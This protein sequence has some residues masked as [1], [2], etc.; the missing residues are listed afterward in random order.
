MEDPTLLPHIMKYLKYNPTF[1]TSKECSQLLSLVQLD[2]LSDNEIKSTLHIIL[3]CHPRSTFAPNLT[4]ICIRIINN[5]GSWNETT[6]PIQHLLVSRIA[7]CDIKVNCEALLNK[8]DL[9]LLLTVTPESDF[10]SC[11]IEK[12]IASF[13]KATISIQVPR[14]S[15]YHQSSTKYTASNTANRIVELSSCHGWSKIKAGVLA[16]FARL[17]KESVP[18]IPSELLKRANALEKIRQNVSVFDANDICK[19]IVQDFVED[20]Q[21]ISLSSDI[22]NLTLLAKFLFEFGDNL[23]LQ[24]FK[25][26]VSGACS[27]R[28]SKISAAFS[29]VSVSD[30][31]KLE[32]KK[33]SY[34][35]ILNRQ[36]QE[37]KI[38]DLRQEC[39]TLQTQ[40][41]SLIR[42]L[43]NG[44]P[45]F[46][47]SMPNAQ[48]NNSTLKSFF[49]SSEVGP[50]TIVVGGG[51]K[52]ARSLA[53]GLQSGYSATISVRGTG[54]N[55]AVVVTKTRAFY[56]AQMK[57]YQ[58]DKKELGNIEEKL[59]SLKAQITSF[60]KS[61]AVGGV[62]ASVPEGTTN[63]QPG[64]AQTCDLTDNVGMTNPP[65]K[66]TR[67]EPPPLPKNVEVIDID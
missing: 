6:E 34:V 39:Q 8:I 24:R 25:Q 16:C 54:R 49:G 29:Q 50:K 32:A 38:Q 1:I 23:H 48:I 2:K 46:S 35:E 62:S 33:R 21:S 65:K 55:A 27:T 14:N 10:L 44:T 9:F 52:Y 31:P 56:D 17:R 42:A 58:D 47:W 5:N 51:V 15:Y 63:H 43:R 45:N 59:L 37:Q 7:P 61:T 57:K 36:L 41:H 26:W 12:S 66:R 28:I 18:N 67:I 30:T 64:L 22:N 19:E 40:Q 3:S 4:K 60:N 53:Y 11:T 13:E 20:I